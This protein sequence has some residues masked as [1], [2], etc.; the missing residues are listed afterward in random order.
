M[1]I[2]KQGF[3]TKLGEECKNYEDMKDLLSCKLQT[4]K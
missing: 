1:A 4:N 2:D 3:I